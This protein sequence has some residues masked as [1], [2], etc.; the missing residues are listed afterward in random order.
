VN[1][2]DKLCFI[3]VERQKANK[4]RR[5]YLA[6]FHAAQRAFKKHYPQTHS[7]KHPAAANLLKLAKDSHE[8][9]RRVADLMNDQRPLLRQLRKDNN[10][11]MS[12]TSSNNCRILQWNT[13]VMAW[14]DITVLANQ[15]AFESIVLKDSTF[16]NPYA[17]ELYGKETKQEKNDTPN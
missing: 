12:Y 9:Y 3:L 6:R 14:K 2:I 7:L 13:T 5:K 15:Y 11:R 17:K 8:S 4:V 1:S 16:V 10:A